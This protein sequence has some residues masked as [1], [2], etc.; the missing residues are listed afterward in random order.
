M[1]RTMY[2]AARHTPKRKVTMYQMNFS[3]SKVEFEWRPDFP[4]S[5]REQESSKISVVQLECEETGE[6][7]A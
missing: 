6:N 4:N 3:Q 7:I 5:Q 2:Q 1:K